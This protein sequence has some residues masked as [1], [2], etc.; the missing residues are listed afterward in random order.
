MYKETSFDDI[1]FW[2]HSP[3]Q[4]MTYFQFIILLKSLKHLA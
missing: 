2:N 1:E 3:P 4:S